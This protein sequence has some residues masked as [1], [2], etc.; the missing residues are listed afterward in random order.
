MIYGAYGIAA[1]TVAIAAAARLSFRGAKAHESPPTDTVLRVVLYLMTAVLITAMITARLRFD[2]GQA[3]LG[4]APTKELTNAAY[5]AYQTI[6]SS[7]MAYWATVLSLGLAFIYLPGALLIDFA[8][9]GGSS[10]VK[11]EEFFQF[12]QENFMRLIRVAA[13]ASPP[14][15]NKLIEAFASAS[16]VA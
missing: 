3:A 11:I 5:A 12:N 1:L 14:I 15:I 6:A 13:I 16:H 2:V 7:V 8:A 10:S 4:P 9:A